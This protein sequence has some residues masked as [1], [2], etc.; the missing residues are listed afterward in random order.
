[1]FKAIKAAFEDIRQGNNLDLYLIIILAFTIATLGLLQVAQFEVIGSVILALL[2]IIASSLLTSRRAVGDL[3]N[4]SDSLKTVISQLEQKD[5][6]LA[7]FSDIT[8][9]G[10]P[11]IK[12]DLR[13]ASKVS[14]L[15]TLIARPVTDYHRELLL[16]LRAGGQVQILLSEPTTEVVSMQLFRS[17]STFQDSDYVITSSKNAIRTIGLMRSDSSDSKALQARVMP[18]IAPFSLINIEQKD[19]CSKSYVRL[20]TFRSSGSEQPTFIIDSRQDSDWYKFFCDQF[21]AMWSASKET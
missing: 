17:S 2:G 10:Y 18:Y 20:M 11:D 4:T 8:H 16:M 13:T 1:M 19:G 3:Q 5:K 9:L 14:I 21:D 12:A 15:S 6:H 7:S